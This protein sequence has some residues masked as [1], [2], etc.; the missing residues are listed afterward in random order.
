[1]LD[2]G[3][4]DLLALRNLFGCDHP[5]PDLFQFRP[6]YLRFVLQALASCRIFLFVKRP[7]HIR[8]KELIIFNRFVG[9]FTFKVRYLLTQ[10]NVSLTGSISVNC[11]QKDA[12]IQENMREN[13]PYRCFQNMTCNLWVGAANSVNNVFRSTMRIGTAIPPVWFLTGSALLAAALRAR[14]G[15]PADGAPNQAGEQVGVTRVASGCFLVLRQKPVSG[16]PLI[17][18]D[19]SGYGNVNP[20][21]LGAFNLALDTSR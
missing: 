5:R 6:K 11:R 14:I 10:L 12:R 9:N 21:L 13:P 17:A 7:S 20:L 18:G 8:A 19:K 2:E 16:K 3:K 15:I 4:Y 1:V